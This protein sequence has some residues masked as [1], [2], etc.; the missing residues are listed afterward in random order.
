MRKAKTEGQIKGAARDGLPGQSARGVG[1]A[2]HLWLP[3]PRLCAMPHR[4]GLARV[5]LPI[6]CAPVRWSARHGHA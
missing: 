4:R 3:V 2:R 6:L 1:A 5:P